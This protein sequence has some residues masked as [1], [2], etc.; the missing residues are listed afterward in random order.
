MMYIFFLS[1]SYYHIV[2][3]SLLKKPFVVY[4]GRSLVIFQEITIY[5]SFLLS[6][7]SLLP[8]NRNYTR[9]HRNHTPRNPRQ[10]CGRLWKQN[11]VIKIRFS[12]RLDL[13]SS[14]PRAP[15]S[16]ASLFLQQ[17]VVGDHLVLIQ[18]PLST[19]FAK[20]SAFKRD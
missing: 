4:D 7:K 18:K 5:F 10:V 9:N 2:L 6:L 20:C 15:F 3:L 13:V 17:P 11:T 8:I 14:L 16:S 1:C 19:T 12:Y